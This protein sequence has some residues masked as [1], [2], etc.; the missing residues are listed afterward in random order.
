MKKTESLLFAC[1]TVQ[2]CCYS[3]ESTLIIVAMFQYRLRH[4]CLCY[5]LA[6]L[7]EVTIRVFV[8]G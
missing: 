8:C 7:T 1:I 4:I 2:V 5:Y 3:D 6:Y